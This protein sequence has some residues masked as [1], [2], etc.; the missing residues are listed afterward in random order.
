MCSSDLFDDEYLD[1]ASAA[2]ASPVAKAIR[3]QHT[4]DKDA[5]K[6]ADDGLPLH[7]VQTLLANLLT[8]AYNVTH[9]HLNPNARIILTTR[10][11]PARE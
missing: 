5:S 9:T 3:S 7:S 1:E 8:L 11:T 6:R 4:K 2:R 10:P